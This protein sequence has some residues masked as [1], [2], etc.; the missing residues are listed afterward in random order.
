VKR[1]VLVVLLALVFLAVFN[2]V[3]F[4][5][6]QER[7]PAVIAS[8]VFV[9]AACLLVL[10]TPPLAGRR[11]PGRTLF[12]WT[13]GAVTGAYFIVE[14]IVGAAF[15]AWG[16]QALTAALTVQVV[17]LGL[18]LAPLFASL[19]AN[20][21]TADSADARTP[22]L[23]FIKVATSEVGSILAATADPELRRSV[24]RVH[25]D[26]R[27]SPVK[28]DAAVDDTETRLRHGIAQLRAD[29]QAGEL[30][31]VQLTA[32]ALTGLIAERNRV[33]RL[34]A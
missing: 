16:K 1:S 22:Q 19:I 26:L 7:T 18:A 10:L 30:A 2:I 32:T 23:M 8:Y 6:V 5:N 15:I 17:L 29:V 9:H 3:F 34:I 14:L 21:A 13:T 28:S 12:G 4:L 11:G 31:Q 33:L 27:A 25:D 20:E 24:E